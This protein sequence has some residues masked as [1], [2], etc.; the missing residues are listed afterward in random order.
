MTRPVTVSVGALA[1]ADDDGGGT[2]QK[3]AGA[4]YLVM[5]GALT[6]GT[7]ANNVCLSQNPGGAGAL[8]LNGSLASSVP[9]GV[10][11]AYL[12]TNRRIYITSAGDL[13]AKN[14]AIVGL[15]QTP[16]GLVSQ[17]ETMIGPNAS[18][19]ASQQQY[20]SITS[21]TI[22]AAAGAAL[23]VGAAGSAATADLARRWSVTSG[24]ND[25]GITF[26]FT[27]T[28]INGTSI[29][30]VVTGAS[31]GAAS[32]TLSFKTVTDVLTSGAAATTVTFGTTA[33]ADSQWV[34]FDTFG[35]MSQV[36]IQVEGSGTVNWTVQQTLDDP[37]SKDGFWTPS[38][39]KW[40][41]HPD[42]AL[43]ASAVTTGVQGNYAY[44]PI[45]AKLVLNSGTGSARAIFAQTYQG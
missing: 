38:S 39:V 5:N 36:A 18:I 45:F 12:G 14:F 13:S 11:V 33:V 37:N 4:K 25:T 10:A 29:S 43:V 41:N 15:Y 24:G 31:G 22:D 42:S 44:T 20:Y 40:V 6:N 9:T 27:G 26:T 19:A 23:T 17:T 28:D 32:T 35:A 2:T 16:T 3:V 8:T 1:T 21:I 34:R 7:T 30:E